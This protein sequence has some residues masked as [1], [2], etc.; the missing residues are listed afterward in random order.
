MHRWFF[1]IY[2]ALIVPANAATI[3]QS[4]LKLD[5]EERAHQVCILKGILDINR[6][7]KLQHVDRLK[8]S[9]LSRA[10][11]DGTTVVAKGGAVRAKNR[12]YQVKFT[13]AVTKDQMKATSFE[14]EIG[15]EIPESKWEDVGL[16]K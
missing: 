11:F 9:I 14:Y 3:D 16:W 15:P 7:K 12:W 4:L 8:T 5:P 10:T 13:C 1:L 2:V 6:A